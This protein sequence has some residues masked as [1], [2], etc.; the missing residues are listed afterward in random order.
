MVDVDDG[1]GE[2]P[3]RL[4]ADQRRQG[5]I[6]AGAI[7]EAGEGIEPRAFARAGDFEPRPV[8][9]A[10]RRNQLGSR[11]L[12]GPADGGVRPLQPHHPFAQQSDIG[13]G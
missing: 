11:R 3:A 4:V 5:R 6:E 8:E 1:A 10:L 13:F 9:F 12:V 2:A 7:G